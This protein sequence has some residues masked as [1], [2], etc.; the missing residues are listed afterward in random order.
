MV[1]DGDLISYRSAAAA[2]KRYII[3]R[4]KKSGREM[5]FEN[6]TEFYGR[7]KEIG[8]ELA[9]INFEKGTNFTR[10][11]FEIEDRFEL[12]PLN[13]AIHIAK[14]TIEGLLKT[15][16]VSQYKI[17]LE[18]S[19]STNFRDKIA[20]INKYKDREAKKPEYLQQ[21]K[22]YLISKHKAIISDT[23]ETDDWLVTEA[24]KNNAIQASID[25]D[26]WQANGTWIFDWTKMDKPFYIPKEGVG[27]IWKEENGKVRAYGLKSLCLQLMVGD[28]TDS[29]YPTKLCEARFGEKGAYD[30]LEM[31]KTPKQCLSVVVAKYKEFYPEPVTY[32]H[33][34][35]GEELTRNWLQIAE[36]IFAL[37]W[38]KRS[39]NDNMT[40]E[41]LLKI[42]KVDYAD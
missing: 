9:K 33:W 25:K 14:K 5:R 37:V 28:P 11:D 3:A 7:C 20:T 30:I 23:M 6:R 29:I 41:R 42:Y 38:M 27:K 19:D 18:T 36:E 32:K 4:H 22:E 16:D 8:G 24:Y 2:E 26:A 31:L 39:E 40:F 12:E 17:Y 10:E 34:S 35:T 15:C 21:V 1:A 13:H